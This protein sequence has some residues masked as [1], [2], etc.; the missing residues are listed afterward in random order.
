MDSELL[1]RVMKLA[2]RTGDR[3]IVVNPESG[4]AFAVLPFEAYEKL[5]DGSVGLQTLDDA[6]DLVF[7]GEEE[8]GIEVERESA[9][10]PEE[11]AKAV[12][13]KLAD[14][15]ATWNLAKESEKELE[16]TTPLDVLDDEA[17]EEQYYLEPIE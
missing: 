5:A 16:N 10:L 3:V 8:L 14:E 1:L 13:K 2:E 6:N 4:K 9:A 11:T 15:I 12:E 17:N 7:P